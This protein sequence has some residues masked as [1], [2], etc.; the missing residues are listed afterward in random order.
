VQGKGRD[1]LE[2]SYHGYF[3]VKAKKIGRREYTKANEKH[4]RRSAD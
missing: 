3:K 2:N 4:Q 1:L